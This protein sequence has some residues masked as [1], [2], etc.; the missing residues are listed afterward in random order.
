[1]SD[2]KL[3]INIRIEISW[4]RIKN[5]LITAF[6]GGSNYWYFIK[7]QTEEGHPADVVCDKTGTLTIVDAEDHEEELGFLNQTII[8]MKIQKF[9]NERPKEL[10][11]IMEE[12]DDAAD[13]DVFLQYMVLGEIV[14]G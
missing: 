13:A 1:M 3:G 7:D 12:N 6:E 4:D 9:A 5:V 10:H 11:N 8:G 2:K 14:Y